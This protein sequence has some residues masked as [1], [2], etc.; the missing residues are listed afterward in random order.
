MALVNTD[1][2]FEVDAYAQARADA[3]SRSRSRQSH[4]EDAS[5]KPAIGAVDHMAYEETPLLQ[6]DFDH[7][8]DSSDE[9]PDE[10]NG[11]DAPEWSGARDFEGKPWWRTPSVGFKS[12]LLSNH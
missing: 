4:P 7:A 2:V 8:E 1:E 6:R 11:R 5:Q 12:R 3:K 9:S 10:G